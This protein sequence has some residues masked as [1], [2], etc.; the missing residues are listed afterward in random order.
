M[1]SIYIAALL[2]GVLGGCK[3]D[4]TTESTKTK[5]TIYY[6][7]TIESSGDVE[8]TYIFFKVFN[9]DSSM[10]YLYNLKTDHFVS[11]TLIYT[12]DGLT[13][14]VDTYFAAAC[15]ATAAGRLTLRTVVDGKVKEVTATGT[16]MEAY[17]SR[18]W[19]FD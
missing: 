12:E 8:F 7:A 5:H 19:S 18:T 6:E 11:D 16:E 17:D 9:A 15:T 1:R 13:N 3:K 4:D 10:E 2:I 14:F